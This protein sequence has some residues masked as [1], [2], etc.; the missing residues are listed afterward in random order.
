MI[1][2]DS[3]V[4]PD[5][6][7]TAWDQRRTDYFAQKDTM[8]EENK[9]GRL[10]DALA[11]VFRSAK[12]P[13]DKEHYA[14]FVNSTEGVERGLQDLKR[15]LSELEEQCRSLRS[16]KEEQHKKTDKKK[17][18]P[19]WNWH[20]RR[21]FLRTIA[22]VVIFSLFSLVVFFML[23]LLNVMVVSAVGFFL[24]LGVGS[25]IGGVVVRFGRKEFDPYYWKN[26]PALLEGQATVTFSTVH[27]VDA[28]NGAREGSVLY[29]RH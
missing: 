23:C 27:R 21:P 24:S 13:L 2:S 5:D 8:P 1:A 18:V 11:V 4:R 16:W 15:L 7:T 12:I 22:P 28:S 29:Q 20:W 19:S 14:Y 10:L 3:V 17:G 9:A 25:G 6:W 26:V